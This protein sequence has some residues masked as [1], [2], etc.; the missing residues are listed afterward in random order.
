LHQP[1]NDVLAIVPAEL[2]KSQIEPA[3]SKAWQRNIHVAILGQVPG[4]STPA[5]VQ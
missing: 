2:H 1:G 3:F 5:D 4:Q